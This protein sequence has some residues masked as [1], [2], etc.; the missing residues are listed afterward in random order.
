VRRT[1]ILLVLLASALLPGSAFADVPQND[2]Q[3]G[4]TALPP[5]YAPG[6]YP[7]TI[8]PVGPLPVGGWTDATSTED[9]TLPGPS[10]LGGA[11]LTRHSMWYR[12]TLLEA[13]VLS[14]KLT[15]GSFQKYQPVVTIYSVNVNGTSQNELACGLGG[16]D[17]L[18]NP[19]ASASTYAST[20]T[21]LI[22]I[23]AVGPSD[24]GPP[25]DDPTLTL[26]ETVQD[27][28]APAIHVSVSGN[29][30]IVGPGEPY[31]FNA[32]ASKDLGTGVDES[33]ATWQF[34]ENGQPVQIGPNIATNPLN[35]K[36]H[37]NTAG[38]HQVTLQLSDKSGNT[39]SYTFSVLV[40]N[41]VAPTVGLR[42][43]VPSPGAR[44]LRVVLTHNVPIRVRLVVLQGQRVLRVILAKLINGSNARKSLTIAL[45]KKV[46]KVGFVA[47]SGVASDLGQYPN[48][49]PL[50]TC[51]V[52]PVHGGGVCG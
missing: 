45:T 39:N 49:V 43:F 30:R 3:A 28:T 22:R 50:L 27:V 35:V 36:H 18:T 21:Y 47:V 20:G 42:V 7:L 29:T 51:S 38:M 12:I 6:S 23:A 34:F 16:S 10:C 52:D 1:V 46:G 32:T 31:T 4:A 48:R 9:A 17:Q 44:R 37:W 26:N 19:S 8:L 14:I 25:S 2:T 13:G 41:F 15:T 33:T 11:V 24:Q 5:V 40:H